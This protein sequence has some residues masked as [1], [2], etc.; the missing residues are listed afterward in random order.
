MK[1]KNPG[2]GDGSK[3]H[4]SQDTGG[5]KRGRNQVLGR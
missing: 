2:K 5:E 1:E 4:L 3:N